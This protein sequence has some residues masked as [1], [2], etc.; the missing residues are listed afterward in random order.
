MCLVLRDCSR[1]LGVGIP[2]P[3]LTTLGPSW[4]TL[5]LGYREACIVQEEEDEEEGEEEELVEGVGTGGA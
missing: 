1:T 5:A 4:T 2:T 3:A